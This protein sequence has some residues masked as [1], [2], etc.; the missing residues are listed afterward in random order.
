VRPGERFVIA[1]NLLRARRAMLIAQFQC[2]VRGE[3]VCDGIVLGIPFSADLL[4]GA[5]S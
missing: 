5:E 1:V 2:F 3:M 4:K